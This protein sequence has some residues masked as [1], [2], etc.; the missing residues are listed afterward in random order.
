M[1]Q[2]LSSPVTSFQ[3]VIFII[4]HTHDVCDRSGCA[5]KDKHFLVR[6]KMPVSIF[7]I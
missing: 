6:M 1:K 2:S 4:I 7:R 3:L 5:I